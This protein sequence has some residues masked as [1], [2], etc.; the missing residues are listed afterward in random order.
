MKKMLYIVLGIIT[1]L[2][3]TTGKNMQAIKE[4]IPPQQQQFWETLQKLCGN[5]YEG[6]VVS[7]PATDTTFKN[8]RLI[9]HIRAC[10]DGKIRIP[11]IVGDNYS[12][13]FILTKERDAL[14]LKH[15]HRHSDGLSDKATMYGG[16]TTNAG[17]L[18]TQYFAA[19]A[20]TVAMLPSAAGNVWWINVQ[21]DKSFTYNLRRLGSDWE[22]SIRFNLTSKIE[23]PAAPWGWKD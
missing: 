19:D 4:E 7:A 22:F 21:P 16:K 15:D 3:C 17:T 23:T 5:S 1:L 8:K 18:T 9:I 20:A 2:G 12:R 11:F 10:E 13:T 6:T 14:Q